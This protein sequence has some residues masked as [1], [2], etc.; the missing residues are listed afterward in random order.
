ML[1]RWELVAGKVLHGMFVAQ[2]PKVIGI[3]DV[4]HTLFA[5]ANYQVLPGIKTAPEE[6]RSLSSL[7]N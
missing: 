4:E 3:D 2:W 5:A 1:C 6:F 7:S